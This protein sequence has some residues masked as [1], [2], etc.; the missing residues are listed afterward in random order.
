MNTYPPLVVKR[1]ADI[2]A[3]SM[4]GDWAL[5]DTPFSYLDIS[6]LVN[7]RS[8]KDVARVVKIRDICAKPGNWFGS[9]DFQGSRFEAADPKFPGLLVRN[10]PNPCGLPFRMMDGRRR[11]HKLQQQGRR[12]AIFYVYEYEEVLSLIRSVQV[13]AG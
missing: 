6:A 11:L 4:Y 7:L 13:N 1:V 8:F 2:P 9:N 12:T 10:M 3:H 5:G